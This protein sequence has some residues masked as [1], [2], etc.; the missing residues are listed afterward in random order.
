VVAS[1]FLLPILAVVA[2]AAMVVA[3]LQPLRWVMAMQAAVLRAAAVAGAELAAQE[4]IVF[5][6][7]TLAVAGAVA[8]EALG[9][10]EAL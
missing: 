6:V 2:L 4:T 10:V 3:D 5:Q 7:A 8:S 9:V 1:H